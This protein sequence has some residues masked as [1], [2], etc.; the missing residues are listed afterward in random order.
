MQIVVEK[1]ELPVRLEIGPNLI[2][3]RFLE[4]FVFQARILGLGK[5]KIKS[6]DLPQNLS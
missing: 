1:F 6:N 2:S 5:R 3:Q 4:S